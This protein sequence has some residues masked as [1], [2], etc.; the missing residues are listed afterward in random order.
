MFALSGNA[1]AQD[2]AA[3]ASNGNATQLAPIIVSGQSSDASDNTTVAAKKSRGAT[4]INTPI[5]E[6]PR[7]V[8]VVTKEEL[9][10]RGAQ[11]IV[12]AVRYS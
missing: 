7:S 1:F 5:L 2:A 9:E 4:K 6:T 10:Q 12:E 3:D 8:S 11:D